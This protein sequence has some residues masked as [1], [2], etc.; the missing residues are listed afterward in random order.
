[1]KDDLELGGLC[2]SLLVS[3]I[4][5]NPMRSSATFGLADYTLVF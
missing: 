3:L 2:S 5:L 4:L 1:M